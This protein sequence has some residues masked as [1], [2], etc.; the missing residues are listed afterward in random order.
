MDGR[1]RRD[2]S[3]HASTARHDK[4][5]NG[6]PFDYRLV[7]LPPA[8]NSSSY[9]TARVAAEATAATMSSRMELARAL[10]AL[11]VDMS[12]PRSKG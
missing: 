12:M 8:S 7:T 10:L 4:K 5:G 6:C 1:W 9:N 2:R 3:I 11:F